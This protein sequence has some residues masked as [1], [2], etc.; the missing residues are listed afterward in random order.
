MVQI[1]LALSDFSPNCRKI[2]YKIPFTKE[3]IEFSVA[4]LANS[5]HINIF[6]HNRLENRG[7]GKIVIEAWG[8]EELI[9]FDEVCLKAISNTN[10]LIIKSSLEPILLYD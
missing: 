5:N 1:Y 7:V 3:K 6:P 9:G 8:E 4:G 2:C 10:Q